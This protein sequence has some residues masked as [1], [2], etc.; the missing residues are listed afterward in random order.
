LRKKKEREGRASKRRKRKKVKQ[1]KRQ[2][3]NPTLIPWG[4]KVETKMRLKR[5]K[6]GGIQ[7][8]SGVL[9]RHGNELKCTSICLS[10]MQIRI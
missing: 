1:R 5:D 10:H 6:S 9:R 4:R 7:E 3:K 2:E 8:Y